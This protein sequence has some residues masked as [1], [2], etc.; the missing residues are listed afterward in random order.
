MSGSLRPLGADRRPVAATAAAV[1]AAAALVVLVVDLVAA[2]SGSGS[3]SAGPGPG[4]PAGLRSW[5]SWRSWRVL[6]GLAL[7]V[8]VL[9]ALLVLLAGL[10]WFCSGLVAAS[11]G[12]LL[13]L[14]LLV[15]L[16][17]VLLGCGLLG[18]RLCGLLGLALLAGAGAH[19]RLG[20][21]LLG[22]AARPGAA[23]AAR[24][25]GCSAPARALGWAG[26]STGAGG[27]S[28]FSAWPTTRLG[29]LMA[30]TSWA[31]FIDPAP[32]TPRPAAID[33]RS[34]SSIELRP[35]AFDAAFLAGFFARST[36]WA[37][38]VTWILRTLRRLRPNE[39][40][41]RRMEVARARSHRGSQET[42]TG[43]YA[44][45][46]RRQV[47]RVAPLGSITRS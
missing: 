14:L 47:S 35:L 15:L 8:L 5:R 45:R 12:L 23:R 31:F 1:A 37:V 43:R 46:R 40:P 10:L 4:G 9:L 41:A 13:V 17:L 26:C 3:G 16:L 18:L 21:G 38:S 44:E 42:G 32:E 7:L 6:L 19:R 29:A 20:G 28:A 11:A 24:L 22:A 36:Q 33:L 39:R 34:A 25:S 30:S 2:G 27:C